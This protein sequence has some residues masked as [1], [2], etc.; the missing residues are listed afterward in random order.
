MPRHRRWPYDRHQV[1]DE[2]RATE[3]EQQPDDEILPEEHAVSVPWPTVRCMTRRWTLG[4]LVRVG[5]P[6]VLVAFLVVALTD[7]MPQWHRSVAVGRGPDLDEPTV[8][9]DGLGAEDRTLVFD[10]LAEVQV[11]H[12]VRITETIVQD[13][14]EFRHGVER[15]IPLAD[16]AGLHLMRSLIVSTTP[17]TPGDVDLTDSGDSLIVRVGDPDLTVTGVHTYRLVYVLEDVVLTLPD[18]TQRARL[19]ALDGW[20]QPVDEIRHHVIAAN[21]R[22]SVST[23]CWS[24]PTGSTGPCRSELPAGSALTTQVDFPAG[25]FDD[26]AIISAFDDLAWAMAVASALILSVMV[27]VSLTRQ[28]EWSTRRLAARLATGVATAGP[29]A[30]EFTPPLDLDPACSLRLR[31]TDRADPTRLTAAIVIDLITDGVLTA[32]RIDTDGRPDWMLRRGDTIA[33]TP[34]EESVV[35]AVLGASDE[36]VLSTRGGEIG[37][38]AVDVAHDVDAELRRRGLLNEREIT[39]R[40][41]PTRASRIVGGLASSVATV[42]GTSAVMAIGSVVVDQRLVILAVG[43]TVC[44]TVISAGVLHDRARLRAYTDAGRAAAWR[45]E[46]FARFF[47]ASEFTHVD[48]ADRMG[49]F[50]EYMGH[51]VAF[52]RLD[53]WVA[54]MS[55]MDVLPD[56][57]LPELALIAQAA[58]W[59]TARRSAITHTSSSSTF[60]PSRSSGGFSGGGSGGGGGGSW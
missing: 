10:V 4:T 20:E 54:A 23:L 32:R 48:A 36:A 17:G 40:P 11:D 50:R 43:L 9:S 29:A 27:A 18:G 21:G 16:D 28:R 47:E 34:Y 37:R 7:L 57:D 8:A 15:I 6:V 45:L 49:L 22:P 30:I 41:S 5:V 33:R 53:G 52:G 39:V 56:P 58:V 26:R 55:T 2:Q 3:G 19:D 31:D 35:S 38:G 25:T 14:R 24:G 13:F 44:G 59:H 46:G 1:A 51:A 12:S 42:L 60:R